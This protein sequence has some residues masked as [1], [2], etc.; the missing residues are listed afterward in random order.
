VFSAKTRAVN[1]GWLRA[2]TSPKRKAA[3][4]YYACFGFI[5]PVDTNDEETRQSCFH[6]SDDLG[7][8]VRSKIHACNSA[9][10]ASGFRVLGRCSC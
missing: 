10:Q 7:K 2:R 8:L 3:N 9:L 6:A 5:T 1:F 4:T